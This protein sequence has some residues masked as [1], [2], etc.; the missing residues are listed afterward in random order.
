MSD[1]RTQAHGQDRS[2][3]NIH[4]DYEVHDWAK[5]F[6]VTPDLLRTAVEAVGPEA[7]N[8]E[9]YLSAEKK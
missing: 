7:T 4:E 1:D 6:G 9:Q 3:I 5:R 2:R 8:V